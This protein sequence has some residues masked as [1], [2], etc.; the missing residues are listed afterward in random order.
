MRKYLQIKG[1]KYLLNTSTERETCAQSSRIFLLYRYFTGNETA[2]QNKTMT[3]S[4]NWT[5]SKM[6]ILTTKP[7][8]PPGRQERERERVYTS[9]SVSLYTERCT[10][11]HW[12]TS[13]SQEE[14]EKVRVLTTQPLHMRRTNT[15]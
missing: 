11:E 7:P 14:E 1:K 12:Y 10:A 13:L 6:N 9:V 2:P 4:V 3:V 8:S 5:G 15:E